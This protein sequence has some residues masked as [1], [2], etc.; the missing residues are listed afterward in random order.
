MRRSIKSISIFFP[1]YNEESN[2]ARMCNVALE[3]VLQIT[4]DY[5]I[6]LVNDGSID[7]TRAAIDA[8]VNKHEQVIG[9]HHEVNGGYGAALQS[10]FKHASKEWVFYTDGD[11]QFDLHELPS[12]IVLTD[13][14]DIIT[15]FRNNRQEGFMRKSNAYCWGKLVSFLFK[16]KI[17]DID[18]AFKLYRN[19]IFNNIKMEST[20]ALIDTE[21]LA[22]AQRAGYTMVQ[23]GVTHHPR[24]SGEST[25]ANISVIIKA[26]KELFTLR[27][28]ILSDK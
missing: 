6:I 11:A 5:E 8:L 3:V 10:G 26:F 17:K 15:C 19:E 2:V 14:Y 4:D 21:I 16:L 28:K 9:L 7:G 22:R 25:G 12:L 23:R 1:F 24:I 27:K 20:G 18:C 13:S